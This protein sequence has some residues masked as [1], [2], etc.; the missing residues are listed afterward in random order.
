MGGASGPISFEVLGE[1]QFKVGLGRMTKALGDMRPFWEKGLKPAF[2]Q[3]EKQQFS[4]EGGAGRHGAWAD[5]SDDYKKWKARHY[6]GRGLLVRDGLL[7]QAL[8]GGRGFVLQS[9][10][11]WVAIGAE[12]T[13]G[14]YHQKGKGMPRRRPIDIS[15]AQ[16]KELFAR[17]FGL[18]A[19]DMNMMWSAGR[20]MRQ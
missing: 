13:Y 18:V 1:R 9:H 14:T 20:D 4:T 19:H 16:E 3:A 7:A 5:L 10:P 12:S 8:T 6:P 2:I 17:V 11:Q 15:D